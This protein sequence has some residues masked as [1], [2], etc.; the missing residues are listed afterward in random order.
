[1][2]RP[3]T[4]LFSFAQRLVAGEV[5][6]STEAVLLLASLFFALFCNGLFLS[7]TLA[8]YDLAQPGTWLLGASLVMGWWLSISCC[9]VSSPRAG[10]P[11]RYLRCCSS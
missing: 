10:R 3:L 8:G 4:A 9:L 1:M 7:G 11:S 2:R 6:L 5:V